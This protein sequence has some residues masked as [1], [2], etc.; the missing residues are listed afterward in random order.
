MYSLSD[1]GINDCLRAY[2]CT[3]NVPARKTTC[4]VNN[5]IISTQR[6]TDWLISLELRSCVFLCVYVYMCVLWLLAILQKLEITFNVTGIMMSVLILMISLGLQLHVSSADS[7]FRVGMY[8]FNYCLQNIEQT[9]QLACMYN[10]SAEI[11]CTMTDQVTSGI[12]GLYTNNQLVV[13]SYPK[14]STS[15]DVFIHRRPLYRK[16]NA[17]NY[18]QTYRFDDKPFVWCFLGL[19]V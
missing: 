16:T 10:Y 7:N 15:L 6:Y 19:L 3:L 17:Y 8:W 11:H 1:N 2:V 12:L 4:L 13:V 14:Q 9:I 18:M 5:K